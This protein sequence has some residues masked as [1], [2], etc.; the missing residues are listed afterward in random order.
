MSNID[1]QFKPGQ[2]GNPAGRPKRDWTWAGVLE[3]AVEKAEESG[4]TV[5]EIVAESLVKEAI[6]GNVMA[7]KEIMNR[8]D[9]MPQQSTD[10]TSGGEPLQMITLDTKADGEKTD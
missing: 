4:K 1:T 10:I 6:K 9:G 2:S 5:K 3:N 7:Q 8:M